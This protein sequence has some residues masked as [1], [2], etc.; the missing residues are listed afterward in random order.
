MPS[1][2]PLPS[3]GKAAAPTPVAEIDLHT[4][5][6]LLTLFVLQHAA[7]FRSSGC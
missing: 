5:L 1:D 2:P 6:F 3:A 4:A 7:F